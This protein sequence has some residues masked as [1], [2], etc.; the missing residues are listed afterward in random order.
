M[1]CSVAG[2][3]GSSRAELDA[4]NE[5]ADGDKIKVAVVFFVC[6]KPWELSF[7][8]ATVVTSVAACA[9]ETVVC[10]NNAKLV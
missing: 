3:V 2:K 8:S 4:P 7:S 10:C 6:C 9:A 5:V 1:V